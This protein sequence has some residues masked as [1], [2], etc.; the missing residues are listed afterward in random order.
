AAVRHGKPDGS[1]D[2]NPT[3]FGGAACACRYPV[4]RR[5]AHRSRGHHRP[6]RHDQVGVSRRRR[7]KNRGL[8]MTHALT[9]AAGAAATFALAAA[10]AFAQ[11]ACD[12]ACLE[13]AMEDYLAAMVDRRTD[14]PIFAPGV[15][16]TENGQAIDLGYGLWG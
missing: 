7:H 8:N 3:Y 4:R 13:G 1:L 15:R 11:S 2:G 5:M 16:Y 6:A 12:R 10:P 9:C 14:S